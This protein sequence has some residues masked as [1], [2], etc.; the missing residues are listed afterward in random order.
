MS[1][2]RVIASYVVELTEDE[3]GCQWITVMPRGQS[4]DSYALRVIATSL[5]ISETIQTLCDVLRSTSR[6]RRLLQCWAYGSHRIADE[7]ML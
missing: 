5:G 6:S 3:S 4:E 7:A 1:S 2:K